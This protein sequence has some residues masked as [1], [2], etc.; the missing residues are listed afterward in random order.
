MTDAR[1]LAAAFVET[2]QRYL[3]HEYMPRIRM[4]VEALPLESL[5]WRPSERANSKASPRRAA[6]K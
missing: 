6:R 4:C 3:T 5:W 2:P 1:D